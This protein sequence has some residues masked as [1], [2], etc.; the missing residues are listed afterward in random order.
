MTD[1]DPEDQEGPTDQIE[2]EQI[3]E[4]RVDE[5]SGHPILPTRDTMSSVG[6]K[7]QQAVVREVFSKAY[8]KFNFFG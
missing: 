5:V 6:L 3:P 1:K 2:R 7:S 8:G 4:V